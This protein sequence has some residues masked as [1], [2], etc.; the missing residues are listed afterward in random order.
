MDKFMKDVGE[1][2]TIKEFMQ[3]N[4]EMVKQGNTLVK[5]IDCKL[6]SVLLDEVTRFSS[7]SKVQDDN[8]V[9][10][11]RALDVKGRK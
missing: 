9:F 2:S 5:S 7:I 1:F 10:I 11:R 3:T 4:S 6:V 8:Y